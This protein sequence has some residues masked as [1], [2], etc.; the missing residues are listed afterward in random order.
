MEAKEE[1]M[2][3]TILGLKEFAKSLP[4]IPKNKKLKK[5]VNQLSYIFRHKYEEEKAKNIE[6]FIKREHGK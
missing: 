4:D 2:L 6:D 1:T 3:E 5:V